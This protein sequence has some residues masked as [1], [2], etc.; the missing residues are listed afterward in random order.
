MW[1]V[2]ILRKDLHSKMKRKTFLLPVTVFAALISLGLSACNN[3]DQPA[4]KPAEESTQQP[5][6]SKQGAEEKITITAAGDKTKLMYGESVQLTASVSGV[7]WESS[8]PEV[9][10]VDANGLVTSV[11]KGSASIKAKKDGY[12]DGSISI[13]VDYPNITLTAADNKTSLLIGET[14]NLT[15]SEQGVT[16]TSSDATVASVANGV[17]TALKLGSTTIKA[18]KE[19]FNDGSIVINVVRPEPTAKLHMEDAEHYDADG[20]WSSSNTP[21]ESPVY[22]KSNASDGTCCAH[23]GKGDKETI[24]FTASK[25]VKAEIVLM[26]G[27]YYSIDDLTATYDVKFND[28]AVNFAAQGYVSEDTSNYTYK[29]LS[30]GE[31]DLIAGTNVLE[32]TMKDPAEGASERYPY[33]DDLNIY[34]AEA[35]TIELVP[36]PALLPLGITETELALVEGDTHQIECAVAEVTYTTSKDTVATVSETGLITAVAKGTATITVKKVGYKAAKIAVTVSEKTVEGEL[37]VEA[38]E[39]TSENDAVTFRQVSS[40]E[41]ATDSFPEGATLII[42]FNATTAGTYVLSMDARGNS[43]RTAID[44]AAGLSMK[45]NDEDVTVSGELLGRT[46]QKVVL[47]EVTVKVGENTLAVTALSGTR[48][49][50]DFFRLTPKAA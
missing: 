4:D 1:T 28:A 10:A 36:A 44:L 33:M 9:A 38:E 26:I 46:F 22:N 21:D 13:S 49:N 42:K 41:T 14:V 40:G 27:Y 11:S 17:V 39:G 3:T 18:S 20:E 50:I 45:F 19:H 47:G 16:W 29:E 30:F 25:A 31:L 24:R 5:A 43:S 2:I 6:D 34:A 8:K 23:F 32:I 37:K 35:V 7:T 15:A 12:K 48:P